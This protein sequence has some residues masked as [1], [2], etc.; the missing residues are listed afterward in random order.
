MTKTECT[1]KVSGFIGKYLKKD[2]AEKLG[3]SVPTLDTRLK[4]N[5]WK[6]GE[7]ELIKILK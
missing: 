7:I 1:A 2:I 5:N 4:Q 3:I 6:K